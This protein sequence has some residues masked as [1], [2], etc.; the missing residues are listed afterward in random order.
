MRT[1]MDVLIGKGLVCSKSEGRRLIHQGS[2]W[3]NDQQVI[4]EET[5]NINEIVVNDGDTVKVGRNV[6]T[7]P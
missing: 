1:I 6:V 5:T 4:T 7:I 3:I 2:I